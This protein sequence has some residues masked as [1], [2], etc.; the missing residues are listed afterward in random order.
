M[1][2]P[3]PSPERTD[4]VALD[5]GGESIGGGGMIPGEGRRMLV[6]IREPRRRLFCLRLCWRARASALGAGMDG[7]GGC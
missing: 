3:A 5:T 4:S 7:G 2:G 1:L 6:K